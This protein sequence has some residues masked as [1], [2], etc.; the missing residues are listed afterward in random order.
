MEPSVSHLF[1]ISNNGSLYPKLAL[2][3]EE[4][5]SY[6]FVVTVTDGAAPAASG[7]SATCL[8]RVNVLDDNDN[9]PVLAVPSVAAVTE[10]SPVNTPVAKVTAKDADEGR[11][12]EV[13]FFLEDGEER[14]TVGRVDGI[15][16]TAVG[17]DREEQDLHLIKVKAVDRGSPR[18]SSEVELKVKILDEN[19]N[20]PVF[21]LKQHS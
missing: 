10:N 14:F 18:L 5:D 11:N 9:A 1:H 8:V 20:P 7:L 3:R 15:V 16:R 12:A 21:N 6:A 4:R 19:D 17:F 13:D 2:D